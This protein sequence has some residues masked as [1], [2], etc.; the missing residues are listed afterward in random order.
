MF[1]IAEYKFCAMYKA[2]FED[3]TGRIRRFN[4]IEPTEMRWHD[5]CPETY[6][7]GISFQVN[8]FT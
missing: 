1:L 5:K 3:E 7:R 8:N 4:D 2:E 6:A